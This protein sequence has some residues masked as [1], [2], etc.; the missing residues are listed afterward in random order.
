M[1]H[2]QYKDAYRQCMDWV[3]ARRQQLQQL[4]DDAGSQDEIKRKLSQLQELRSSQPEGELRYGQTSSLATIVHQHTSP[5]GCDRISQ[6]MKILKDEMDSLNFTTTETETSLE[7]AVQ[8]LE[9]FS[10]DHALFTN[11]LEE[12]E[13]K[14][15]AKTEK[16]EFAAPQQQEADFE[17]RTHHRPCV[18]IIT[19]PY[20]AL[21]NPILQKPKYYL[22]FSRPLVNYKYVCPP[23]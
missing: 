22:R 3:V 11:W 14:V 20:H 8:G 4:D 18:L 5:C 15:K 7:C 23:N 6:E 16:F 10:T 1:E 12:V 9:E 17:V 2:D 13:E 21:C 19:C